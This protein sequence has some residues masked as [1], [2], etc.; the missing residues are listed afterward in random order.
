MRRCIRLPRRWHRETLRCTTLTVDV[1][2]GRHTLRREQGSDLLHTRLDGPLVA[3]H[4]VLGSK[5][6]A[7]PCSRELRALAVECCGEM[8]PG[9]SV[10]VVSRL[11]RSSLR[12]SSTILDAATFI[13]HHSP[14]PACPRPRPAPSHASSPLTAHQ[15]QLVTLWRRNLSA[16]S[17]AAA[18]SCH[19]SPQSAPSAPFASSASFASS[20]LSSSTP[21]SFARFLTAD[22]SSL[23]A[24]AQPAASPP[25]RLRCHGGAV[26]HR[27]IVLFLLL[28]PQSARHCPSSSA[29]FAS[30][31]CPR[32]RPLLARFLTADSFIGPAPSQLCSFPLLC[33][34][35]HR[36]ILLFLLLISTI[37]S[38]TVPSSSASFASSNCPRPH[39]A[40]SHASH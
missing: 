29:S 8:R 33:F 35:V 28:A 7:D 12:D 22:P 17:V 2:P 6:R 9:N 5:K 27:R 38:I 25:A 31:S 13:L 26:Q 34:V 20:S 1:H 4:A 19:S 11:A 40:P 30:S 3:E 32:P 37:S 23:S 24:R 36:K 15:R 18:T 39:L 14:L 16:R 21:A 10:P